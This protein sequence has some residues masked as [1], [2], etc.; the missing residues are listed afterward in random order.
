M[1]KEEGRDK[2]FPEKKDAHHYVCVRVCMREQAHA[3]PVYAISCSP[4]HRNLFLTCSTDGS[5]R[6]YNLLQVGRLLPKKRMYI[7]ERREVI[8]Y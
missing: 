2:Y 3:G 4:F 5:V 8:N 1:G 6:L 7:G